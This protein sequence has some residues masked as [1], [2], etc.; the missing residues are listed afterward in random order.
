MTN[1]GSAPRRGLAEGMAR[2]ATTMREMVERSTASLRAAVG[3]LDGRDGEAI[4]SIFELDQ[5]LYATKQEVVKTCVELLALHAPVARDLRTITADLEIAHDL[6]RVGRYAKDIAEIFQGL[7]PEDRRAAERVPLLRRMGELT[8]RMVERVTTALIHGD[9]DSV[10]DID[11]ADNEVDDLHEQVFRD[12][13]GRIA[14]QS[15][16]PVAGAALILVNRYFER[17]ADHAVNVGG[18][19]EYLLSGARRHW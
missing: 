6:D 15:V 1:E 3:L 10:R 17:L 14:D 11:T 19:V 9:L 4:R 16:S 7:S 8:V 13:V 2:L 12:L 18:H 5:A